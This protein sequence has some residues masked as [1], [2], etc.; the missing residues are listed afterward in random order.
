MIRVLSLNV[1]DGGTALH[2][3]LLARLDE[4]APDLLT[5]QEIRSATL[6]RWRTDLAAA[7]Y[8]L[9]DTFEL[10]RRHGHP[11]PGPFR[12]DGLLIASR[13]PITPTD[14]TGWGLP[15]PER[16]L[17]VTVHHPDRDLELHTVHVP[18]ASTGITLYRKGH[19]ALGRERLMKKLETFEGVHRALTASPHTP[20]ILT[21]D[22]NTP[23][24]ERPDGTVRYWQHSCPA[25][26]RPELEARWE[27]AERGVVEGLRA[28]GL[29]DAYRHVHGP[30]GDAFSWEHGASGN[31]YRYDHV[32]AS[33]EFTAT[34]CTYLHEFRLN[35]NHHAGILA[36]LA[37]A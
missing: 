7:G 27:A 12:E 25:A 34:G 26:L 20:R 33:R 29:T 13:W 31:R 19:H 28:H 24:T 14:P 1:T 4:L 17:S 9:A 10:A 8:H 35:G 11:H 21:G 23:H 32:F 16:L 18:N 2:R 3:L 22:L 36:E 30:N 6:G 37:W 5:L 15:W